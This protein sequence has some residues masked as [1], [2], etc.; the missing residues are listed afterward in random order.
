MPRRIIH[1]DL[2]VPVLAGS[3]PKKAVGVDEEAVLRVLAEDY[4]VN[5]GLHMSREDIMA[6]F[7]TDDDELDKVLIV[8]ENKGF[9]KL[10]RDK[11][12]IAL[13]KATYEGLKKALPPKH[14]QWFPPWSK[15]ENI[16]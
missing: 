15:E 13:A 4:R 10:Y 3:P 5:P 6:Y 12:G 9:A 2:G 1:E 8:L 14:Y 16:F 11:K 7:T